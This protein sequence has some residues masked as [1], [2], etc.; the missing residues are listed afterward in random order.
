MSRQDISN[1][2]LA[3][4]SIM[5]TLGIGFAWSAAC[6]ATGSIRPVTGIILVT[7]ISDIALAAAAFALLVISAFLPVRRHLAMGMVCGSAL[8]FFGSWHL[9]MLAMVSHLPGVMHAM[10]TI[11]MPLGVLT[12]AV[13]IFHIGRAYRLSRLLLGSYRKIE[14]S[15]ATRDQIT[16]LFNRRYFYSNCPELLKSC[17]KHNQPCVLIVMTIANLPAINQRYGVTA[18]DA[19]LSE[20][21][22]LIIKTTR[23]IDVAARLGGRRIAIFLPDTPLEDAAH[24]AKRELQLCEKVTITNNDGERTVITLEVDQSIQQA[25]ANEAFETLVDRGLAL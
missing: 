20:L 15:L 17:Q 16:Q 12:L 25:E 19:A 11:A 24:I 8:L 4:I 1:N 9:L 14:H 6:F 21:G 13:A 18:G 23:R 7:V 2:T 22:R 10:G 3:M 5:A